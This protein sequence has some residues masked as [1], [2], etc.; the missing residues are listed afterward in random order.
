MD[1]RPRRGVW[2]WVKRLLWGALIAIAALL[3]TGLLYQT[4]ANVVA[5]NTYPPPGQLVD[6]GGHRLH[7]Y[8]LGEG[9][10][11]VILETGLGDNSTIWS[12]VTWR[13]IVPTPGLVSNN[14]LAT[15]MRTASL[16]T[17][18][19]TPSSSANSRSGG[20]FVPGSI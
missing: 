2:W 17:V 6:V 14:P 15:R 13:T 3:A 8:C 11:T 18:R 5:A 19:L 10:P 12:L 4:A 9:S 16:T 7:L 20:S 1:E